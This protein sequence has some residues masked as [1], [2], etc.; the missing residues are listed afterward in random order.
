MFSL[1]RSVCFLLSDRLRTDHTHLFIVLTNCQ[2]VKYTKLLR[3][4]VNMVHKSDKHT[5]CC[6]CTQ[7]NAF[8]ELTGIP[9]EM[10]GFHLQFKE[11]S[12]KHFSCA[13]NHTVLSATCGSFEAF[14]LY[15]YKPAAARGSLQKLV[16][17][18]FIADVAVVIYVSMTCNFY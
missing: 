14:T 2:T 11:R 9:I 12:T 1:L 8:N 3:Q 7:L 6:K 18:E 13:V 15:D 10:A 4:C 17:V 5:K 16:I